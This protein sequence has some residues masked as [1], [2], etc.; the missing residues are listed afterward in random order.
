MSPSRDSTARAVSAVSVAAG[1]RDRVSLL[2]QTAVLESDGTSLV[3]EPAARGIDLCPEEER[4]AREPE[5]DQHD[6]H[7][8]ERAPRLVVG[9]EARGVERESG[10]REEPDHERGPR[11]GGNE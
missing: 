1:G 8:G 3:R 11:P 5:P 6:D 9:A 2:R 7:G 10:G 4:R